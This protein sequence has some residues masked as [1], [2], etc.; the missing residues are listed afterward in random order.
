MKLSVIIPVFNENG[1]IGE[2]VAKTKIA[3]LPQ[4]WDKEIIIVDDGSHDGTRDTLG[5]MEGCKIVLS[6]KN[7]GKGSALKEGMKVATGDYILIQDADL[8]YDPK[9]YIALLQPI[10]EGRADIVFGSRTLGMNDVPFSRVY[11]YGGLLVTKVFNLFFGSK[12]SDVATCYKVF[13]RSYAEGL[14]KL[15]AQDFVFDVVELSYFLLKKSRILEVPIHY[16]S[17]AG[18]EGKKLNWR[19][20]YRCLSRIISLYLGVGKMPL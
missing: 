12:L 9:D 4:G 11:F 8:E 17:R 19:H 2:V 14:V 18:A 6:E 10:A 16:E 1:T 3:L 7:G 5:R 13:P 20:G 15:P